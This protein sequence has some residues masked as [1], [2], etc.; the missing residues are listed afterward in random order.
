MDGR[1]G[2]L[3]ATAA[4]AVGAWQ[5]GWRGAL[6]GLTVVVFW[7]LLQFSRSL[8]VLREA[9]AAPKGSVE[10]GRA[11]CRERVS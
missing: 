1:W 9:G 6:L 8:R 11:S 4:V 2:W 3:L 10:I 5:W 7:L